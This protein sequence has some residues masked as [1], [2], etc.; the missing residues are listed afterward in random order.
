M[1]HHVFFSA[2]KFVVICQGSPRNQRTPDVPA[3]PLCE[4][5]LWAGA[6]PSVWLRS[7]PQPPHLTLSPGAKGLCSVR[8]APKT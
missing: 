2:S 6:L 1:C 3:A 4:A 8:L 5:S 7:G